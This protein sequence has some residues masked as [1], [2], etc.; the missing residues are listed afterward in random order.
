MNKLELT[1]TIGIDNNGKDT[2]LSNDKEWQLKIDRFK[3]A[4]LNKRVVVT[5]E[6][7]DTPQHFC[8]KFYRGYLLPSI[9]FYDYGKNDLQGH[10]ELKKEILG[11]EIINNDMS[12]IGKNHKHGNFI[13][14]DSLQEFTMYI[15]STKDITHDEFRGFIRELEFRLYGDLDGQLLPWINEPNKRKYYEQKAQEY[16]TLGMSNG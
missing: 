5:F 2:F 13:F 16:R 12:V 7:T 8:H 3:A 15:P 1:S 9:A 14:S 11:I 6:V 10:F 4:N